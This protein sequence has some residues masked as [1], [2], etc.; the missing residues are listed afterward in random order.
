MSKIEDDVSMKALREAARERE[1]QEG[2]ARYRTARRNR[3]IMTL[4]G[5]VSVAGLIVYKVW[6][7][8]SEQINQSASSKNPQEETPDQTVKLKTNPED[9]KFISTY[10]NKLPTETTQEVLLGTRDVLE[11]L[12]KDSELSPKRRAAVFAELEKT[13]PEEL[14]LIQDPYNILQ[15]LYPGSTLYNA[16]IQSTNPRLRPLKMLLEAH[17]IQE[18]QNPEQKTRNLTLL[19]ERLLD[20]ENYIVEDLRKLDF[21]DTTKEIRDSKDLPVSGASILYA[22][23]R[24]TPGP[25][26]TSSY[27]ESLRDSKINRQ[28]KRDV[29]KLV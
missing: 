10:L 11:I 23:P 8:P 27:L 2:L 21:E 1:E 7:K 9:T 6:E 16:L 19:L 15:L 20:N 5:V 13:T 14:L 3:M 24:P 17:P 26:K 18:G 25:V 22:R 4:F 12:M 29:F 28:S